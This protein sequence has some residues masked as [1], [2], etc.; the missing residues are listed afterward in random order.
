MLFMPIH[1]LWAIDDLVVPPQV[2]DS[3]QLSFMNYLCGFVTVD[4][5]NCFWFA[6]S[7]S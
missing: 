5:S 2:P 1:E 4:I 7:Y 6:N 3:H